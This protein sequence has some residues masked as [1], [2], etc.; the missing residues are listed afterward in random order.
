MTDLKTVLRD[1]GADYERTMARFMGNEA[2]YLRILAM[3]PR[4]ESLQKLD[5][6]LRSGDCSAAFDAAHTLKGVA[7]NLGLT[8]LAQAACAIVEPLRAGAALGDHANLFQSVQEEFERAVGLL[9]LL[10]EVE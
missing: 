2:L 9:E 6:A 8:P 7:V 4:D 3:L 10:K 1:Y 5:Q